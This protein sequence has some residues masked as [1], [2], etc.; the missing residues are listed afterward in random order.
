MALAANSRV[1]QIVT[2]LRRGCRETRKSRK[3]LMNIKD[4]RSMACKHHER[5]PS[6]MH[7]DQRIRNR[8]TNDP[9]ISQT[10]TR[11]FQ[12]NSYLFFDCHGSVWIGYSLIT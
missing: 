4:R 11:V 6:P 12:K 1:Q 8:A 9:C 3:T 7:H 5:E 10:I 2:D